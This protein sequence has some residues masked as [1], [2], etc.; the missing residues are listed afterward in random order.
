V[1]ARN[2]LIDRYNT[3]INESDAAVNAGRY[4]E[5]ARLRREA[6]RQRGSLGESEKSRQA[7]ANADNYERYADA[8]DARNAG[9]AA[10]EA[11]DK[12]KA[13]AYYQAM[14]RHPGFDNEGNRKIVADLQARVQ[15]ENE[16]RI[17]AEKYRVERE[18]QDR[19]TA[20]VLRQKIGEF[21]ASLDTAPPRSGPL[22]TQGGTVGDALGTHK[23]NA[24]QLQFGDPNAQEAHAAQARQGF[25]GPGRLK[26]SRPVPDVSTEKIA[27]K[28][29]SSSALSAQVPEPAKSDPLVKKSLAWYDRLDT[30]K[31]ETTRKIAT[32]KAQQQSGSGDAA[33]LAAQLGS[34]TNDSKRIEK[35]QAK[36]T[37]DLK[38]QVKNLGLD[39]NESVPDPK[40]A[41][42]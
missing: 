9:N 6:V 21:T 16:Q 15:A 34:L 32:V 20:E 12:A 14:L 23:A 4:R 37:A 1:R 24:P 42:K 40:A 5:A 2:V 19:K 7:L 33:V 27:S 41:S 22:V 26:G 13:L 3:K 17:A 8:D 11:G 18:A 35:D 10:L 29:L 30:M 38:K 25:D 39:W 36:A 31:A 28:P